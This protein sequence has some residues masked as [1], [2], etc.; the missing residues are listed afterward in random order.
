MKLDIEDNKCIF[1]SIKCKGGCFLLK[2]I[3][4]TLFMCMLLLSGCGD[5][6][7]AVSGI[8]S[9]AETAAKATSTDVH[10]I[11]ATKLTYNHQH[12]T[13]NDLFKTVLK[14]VFWE[15]EETN[16]T[17]ILHIKGTWKEP[18]FT[19]YQFDDALKQKLSEDGDVFV[20]LTVKD[21][22]II[23]Q[24]T[25]IQLVYN[26]EILVEESGKQVFDDLLKTYTSNFKHS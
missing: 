25:T 1:L 17:H 18:L 13:V 3:I 20:T 7:K 16:G 12:F 26:K 14:D 2:H 22:Q 5:L 11:R 21:N 8:N 24:N 10:S 4:V 23:E 9:A 15:Y 19:S 6:Q